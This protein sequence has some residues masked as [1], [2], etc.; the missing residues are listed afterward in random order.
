MTA[1]AHEQ[2]QDD[3]RLDEA[4]I[5]DDVAEE[6]LQQDDDA[7]DHGGGADDGGADE[8]R[9]GRGLEGVARAVGR[10]EIVFRLF[11]VRFDAEVLP[12]D[13]F[14]VLAAFDH[15]EF[16]DGLGVVRDRAEAVH[17]DR[18]RAHAEETEGDEAEG[19]DRRGKQELLGIR[20]VTDPL[21]E[22]R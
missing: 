3:L 20:P 17:G 1:A 15:G 21:W 18:D 9:L 16:I 10:L 13:L 14:G 2:A 19:E 8:H 5:G 6:A 7:E 12:D 4:E 22:T 11:E